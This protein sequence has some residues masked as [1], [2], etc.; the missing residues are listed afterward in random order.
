MDFAL[1]RAADLTLLNDYR[2]FA[3]AASSNSVSTDSVTTPGYANTT[4]TGNTATTTYSGGQTIFI[5]KPSSRNTVVMFKEKPNISGL[6]F[7][8]VF[9]CSSIGKKYDVS[10][11]AFNTPAVDSAQSVN[12]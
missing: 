4:F 9:I 2:F 8:A 3:L 6:V 10:C 1:L 7:D 5:S 11:Q 12:K